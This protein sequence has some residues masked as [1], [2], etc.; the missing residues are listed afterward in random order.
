[1]I[2]P[3]KIIIHRFGNPDTCQFILLSPAIGFDPVDCIHC[4]VSP[5][6]EKIPDVEFFQHI[7]DDR[8]ITF[9]NLVTR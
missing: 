6:Q 8:K 5:Y 2:S 7:K 4:I 1:M 9:L 3:K